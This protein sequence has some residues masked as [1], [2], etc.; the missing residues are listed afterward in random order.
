MVARPVD[1][2]AV[3][4]SEMKA[5]FSV[6]QAALKGWDVAEVYADPSLAERT[7]GWR[8]ELGIEAMCRDAWRWQSQNPQGYPVA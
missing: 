7:L 5:Q 6:P 8:A 1:L 4:V 3:L 2:P